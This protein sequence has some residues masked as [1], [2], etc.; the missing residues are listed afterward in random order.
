[1]MAANLWAPFRWKGGCYE[2]RLLP[3]L[4]LNLPFTADGHPAEVYMQ[5]DTGCPYSL[6]NEVPLAKLSGRLA[7]R[8]A[9]VIG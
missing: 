7:N 1:M 6:I 8:K 4:T 2:G 3:K 9:F 5:L